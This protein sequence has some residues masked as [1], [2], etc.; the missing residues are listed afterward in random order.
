[1]KTL[2][3]SVTL[4]FAPAEKVPECRSNVLHPGVIST[5]PLSLI[6]PT[7]FSSLSVS[8]TLSPL[9]LRPA[10]FFVSSDSSVETLANI[11]LQLVTD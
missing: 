7:P 2:S 6:I 8:F 1:M 10:H 5:V 4:S 9:F 3:L 11:S